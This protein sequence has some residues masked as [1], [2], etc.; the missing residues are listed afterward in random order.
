ML[1]FYATP[2]VIML[3]W[4]FVLYWGQVEKNNCLGPTMYYIIFMSLWFYNALFSL[5][6]FMMEIQ[7]KILGWGHLRVVNFKLLLLW[8]CIGI[9]ICFVVIQVCWCLGILCWHSLSSWACM[10]RDFYNGLVAY[11]RTLPQKTCSSYDWWF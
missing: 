9:Y 8:I 3:N 10:W 11:S 2:L 5:L 7:L 1:Q 6:N 4:S